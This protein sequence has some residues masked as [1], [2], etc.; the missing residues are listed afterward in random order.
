MTAK[1]LVIDDED[2]IL[3]YFNKLLTA[4][5]Y[6]VVTA[7]NSADGC[8]L[9]REDADIRLIIT[10]LT[11]AGE[12]SDIALVRELRNIR[13]ECPIV[14]ISGHPTPVRLEECEQLGVREFLT[15]PFELSFIAS[16]LARLL[17]QPE[18]PA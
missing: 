2:P 12:I 1:I 6:D 17:Q 7:N 9:A 13:P 10:D 16:V 15:K 5:K 3:R 18:K 11:M 4:L 14:V 8:R